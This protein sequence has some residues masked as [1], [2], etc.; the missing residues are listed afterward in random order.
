MKA[1]TIEKYGVPDVLRLEEIDKPTP[2]A[3]EVLVRVRAAGANI[4]DCY[5][6]R[7]RPYV[8]RLATGLFKPKTHGLGA[9]FAGVVEAVGQNVT[10]FKPGDEVF[11]EVSMGA[12]FAEY[13]CAPEDGLELKPANLTFEQAAA[14]PM[15]ALTALQALRDKGHIA[16]G[17][18]VLINGASGGVGTF[19]VQIAK[20]FDAE[21]TGVC[22]TKNVELIRSL[23]ADHVVDYT[24]EDFT[25]SD[26]RY[27]LMFDNVGNHSLLQCRRILKP[28]ATYI[29]NGGPA[30][31]WLGPAAHLLKT[32]MLAPFVSQKVTSLLEAANPADLRTLKDLLEAEKITP[33]VDR[34]YPLAET[35]E[36]L[37]YLQ[38]RHARGKVVITI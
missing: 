16:A 37:R 21:V 22:S 8:M 25:G 6:S 4:A 2:G 28:D 23:G 27:D 24:R 38:T 26:V 20:S 17:Q 10:R 14:V 32:M 1:I 35:R 36:A 18:K 11:G 5:I 29:S 7:G 13:T 31:R 34:T 3:E 15:S 9:N 30:G 12:C 19:A 33:F